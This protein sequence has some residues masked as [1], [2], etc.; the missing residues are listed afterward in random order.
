MKVA[1]V[2]GVYETEEIASLKPLVGRRR[3]DF[4]WMHTAGF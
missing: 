4:M 1:I 2:Q 3:V